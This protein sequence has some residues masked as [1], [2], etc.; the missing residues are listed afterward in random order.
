MRRLLALL[1]ALVMLATGCA[2]LTGRREAESYALY[3][4]AADLSQSPGGDA[5]RTEEIYLSDLPE[6]TERVAERLLEELLRGPLNEDLKTPFPAGTTLLSLSLSGAVATV[7][8][9]GAYGTLS[10]VALTLADYAVTLTLTQL[11]Q[12]S[13][14]RIMVRG[15]ELAYRDKQSFTARDVLLSS[16]EDVVGTVAVTLWFLNESGTLTAEERTLELYEGDTQVEAVLKAMEQGPESKDLS[17]VLPEGLRIRSIWV[18]EGI[19]YVNLPSAALP[20][21]AEDTLAMGLHALVRSL[22]SL[23]T[24]EEVQFLVDGELADYY[25]TFPVSEPYLP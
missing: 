1:C 11:P 17:A 15:Q 20:E 5:L 14:V 4:R 21:T 6:E 23:D 2:A 25:G 19:C 7:D 22:G 3:F 18:E 8:L 13:V 9:S 10:G 24:V 16:T 12:I